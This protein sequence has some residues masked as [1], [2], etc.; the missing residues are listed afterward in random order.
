MNGVFQL[1]PDAEANQKR[2]SFLHLFLMGGLVSGLVLIFLTPPMQSPD[3]PVH[4]FRGYLITEGVWMLDRQPDRIIAVLPEAVV[5]LLVAYDKLIFG[6][7]YSARTIP[8]RDLWQVRIDPERT[9]ALNIATGYMLPVGYL[10]QSIGIWVGRLFD[11]SPIALFYL[12]RFTNLL[13]W[14]AVVALSLYLLPTPSRLPVALA[15]AP[16]SIFLAA[17]CSYDAPINGL[18]WLAVA[19]AWRGLAADSVKQARRYY[20]PLAAVLLLIGTGKPAYLPLFLLMVAPGWRA[21]R[22]AH[23]ERLAAGGLTFIASIIAWRWAVA[24]YFIPYEQ[25][26]PEYRQGLTAVPGVDPGMQFMHIMQHPFA[27]MNILVQKVVSIETAREWIGTLGWL[28]V[29]LPLWAYVIFGILIIVLLV[30][31]SPAFHPAAVRFWRI[32]FAAISMAVIG[33][34]AV[35]LYAQWNAVAATTINGI[36]GRY[37]IP[38]GI[39]LLPALQ[40]PWLKITDSA[41]TRTTI[42]ILAITHLIMWHSIYRYY[43]N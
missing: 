38:V 32:F 9:V 22:Q 3:E 11:V 25:F 12:G 13:F 34:I 31:E 17:S 26:A 5:D 2:R 16:M 39:L 4:F 6:T 30:S 28:N 43:Y 27:F 37:F 15:L 10:P 41:L 36:Q 20:L 7:G 40:Y 42:A 21:G 35:A 8:W 33:A 18:S 23:L 24:K 14:M 1:I 19:L 29:H